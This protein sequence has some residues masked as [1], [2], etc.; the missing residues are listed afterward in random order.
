M[1]YLSVNTQSLGLLSGRPWGPGDSELIKGGPQ[2]TQE[3]S[4]RSM[5]EARW[6]PEKG[7]SLDLVTGN[8]QR[9]SVAGSGREVYGRDELCRGSSGPST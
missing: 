3:P 9:F 6:S 7:E 4:R 5:G 1:G 2:V 8:K